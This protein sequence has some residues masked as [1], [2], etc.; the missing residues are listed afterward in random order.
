M[1]LRFQRRICIA[2]GVRLNL[3]LHGVG[4]S[5][6]PRGLHVGIK[7]RGAYSSA[8][9]PGTGLYAV[10]HYQFRSDEPPEVRG[11]ARA[12]SACLIV[13]AAIVFLVFKNC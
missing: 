9:I 12:G 1:P 2:P 13:L 5:V 3:G 7:R 6:G 4:V 11:S 10:Y 8:G